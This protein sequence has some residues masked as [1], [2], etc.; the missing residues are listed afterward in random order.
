M[1]DFTPDPEFDAR[2]RAA[3]R[4][5]RQPPPPD[6]LRHL[7]RA[8][9]NRRLAQA[10]GALAVVAIAVGGIV[11]VTRGGGDGTITTADSTIATVPVTAPPTVPPPDTTPVTAPAT[12]PA[13]TP[14]SAPA[15]VP[16]T[17]T[18][19]PSGVPT[20]WV[21]QKLAGWYADG[22]FVPYEFSSAP[23]DGVLGTTLELVSVGDTE[24][25]TATPTDLNCS[26]P[27]LDPAPDTWSVFASANAPVESAPIELRRGG[28][29]TPEGYDPAQIRV[30]NFPGVD[31][32]GDGQRL[33]LADGWNA[34]FQFPT[35]IA[36]F[37]PVLGE[38][39][40][41]EG[42]LDPANSLD[43]GN[44]IGHFV[45]LDAD[46]NWEI[47]FALG[48]GWDVRELPNNESIVF[49]DGHPCPDGASVTPPATSTA[50][51]A[52]LGEWAFDASEPAAV[53][54]TFDGTSTVARYAACADTLVEREGAVSVV[55][56]ASPDCVSADAD[57]RLGD[58]LAAFAAGAT[59]QLDETKANLTI[60]DDLTLTRLVPPLG[61]DLDRGSA[62]GFYA[63]QYVS[64]VD[65]LIDA[66][67]AEI[68]EPT[69]DTGWFVTPPTEP[70]GEPDCL[71]EMSTRSIWWGDF[72]ISLWPDTATMTGGTIWN[73]TLGAAAT[74]VNV[75]AD[76]PYTPTPSGLETI[77]GLAPGLPSSAVE[78][79]FGERFLGW[80]GDGDVTQWGGVRALP[81]FENYN[82]RSVTA[83][84]GVLET[85]SA[86]KTFC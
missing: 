55:S 41:I 83:T 86:Q 49:G 68:G 44:P 51:D 69:H 43:T 32:S 14:S 9:R 34:E 36:V 84:D 80:I 16:P 50:V 60:G 2:A 45:D 1:S 19:L 66:V 61:L 20:V 39:T 5:L 74:S 77:E 59:L 27:Y 22:A 71:A 29:E 8:R 12:A 48:D 3:G 82:D 72:V 26:T 10:G 62:F 6:G 30:A 52:M 7:Q 37:D 85:I 76:E 78:A 4:A 64:D 11:A 15:T 81:P 40:T 25:V 79:E 31:L 46:G 67:S 75:F 70:P 73:W 56:Q 58:L 42:D 21:G 24:T 65:I 57:A 33:V 18:P 28:I 17:N 38:F 35:W 63:G 47:V 13:A 53:L 23:P 54:I